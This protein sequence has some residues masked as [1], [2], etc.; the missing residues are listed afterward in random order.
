S[1]LEAKIDYLFEEDYKALKSGVTQSMIQNLESRVISNKLLKAKLQIAKMILNNGGELPLNI[2]GYKA[3]E[4]RSSEYFGPTASND[5]G[6]AMLGKHYILPNTDYILVVNRDVQIGLANHMAKPG[7]NETIHL[8]KGVNL[9]NTPFEG[10]VIFRGSRKEKLEYYSLSKENGL[11]FRYGYDKAIDLFSKDEIISQMEEN[12]NSNLGYLEGNNY[13]GVIKFDWLKQNFQPENLTKHIEIAD[14]YLDFLYYL[15]N[16]QGQFKEHMPYRRLMWL[17]LGSDNPHAG[18]SILGAYTGY[19]GSSSPM[20]PRG[21]YDMGNSW[22]IAHEIGHEIDPN[23]YLMGLFGEVAN[24]WY[25]EQGKHEFTKDVRCKGNTQVI[26]ENPLPI[27]E[28]GYFDK[29]AV[30]YKMRLFYSDNSF[31]QKLNA[32]MQETRANNN[33]EAADNYSKF[34]TQILERD[35]SSYLMLYGFP[36]SEEA[37]AWCN[38]YP[39]PA[40]DLRYLTYENHVQFIEEEIKLFNQKYKAVSKIK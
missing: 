39:A 16:V 10:Q 9:I 33:Q 13:I 14:E 12:A 11:S 37:I 6:D 40:I 3:L 20:M 29:L 7:L 26:A 28:Y 19:S 36:L 30:F 38:Q 8:K 2:H 23:D 18:G 22:A 4:K 25:A 32:L 21:T 35:M 1:S 31:F 34:F 5:T 27:A 15:D 17:G 24:N